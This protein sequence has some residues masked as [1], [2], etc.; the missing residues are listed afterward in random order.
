MQFI[1]HV[2]KLME[3]GGKSPEVSW[4]YQ[5]FIKLYVITA[6]LFFRTKCK[7]VKWIN[8]LQIKERD[9]LRNQD[10]AYV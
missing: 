5:K 2:T 6:H 1:F 8:F 7:T 9:K 3:K 4:N 10:E